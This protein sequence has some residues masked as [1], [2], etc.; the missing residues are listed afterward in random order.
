MMK[1]VKNLF[2]FLLIFVL[3]F[4]I[5][6]IAISASYVLYLEYHNPS[7]TPLMELRKNQYKLS[8]VKQSFVKLKNIPRNVIKIVL[9]AEDCN[10]YSHPGIDV[11]GMKLAFQRNLRKGTYYY[12]GSTISQQ[13]ARTL[14]LTPE[15]SLFRKYLELVLTFEIETILGKN[16]ILE[17]YLNYAEWGKG[18][19]GI[20]A[21]SEYFFGKGIRELSPE[22][23]ISLVAILPNP[24]KYTP[25]STSRLVQS[26]IE[27]IKDYYYQQ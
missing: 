20:Q 27:L 2:S 1:L 19:F 14:M 11:E 12:G 9:I 6:F 18:I 7:T 4:H 23:D 15:K 8:N 24:K 5:V 17:L 26:R 13:T 22:E 21:A 3:L 25:F 10:F 16:R